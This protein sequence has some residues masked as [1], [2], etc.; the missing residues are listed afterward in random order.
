MRINNNLY[1]NQRGEII[2]GT[3]LLGILGLCAISGIVVFQLEAHYGGK[4]ERVRIEKEKESLPK[5]LK[6]I[7]EHPELNE[8]VKGWIKYGSGWVG[9]TEEQVRI[10][11][12]SW[13]EPEVKTGPDLPLGADKMLI[14][15]EA[16]G[17]NDYYFLKNNKVI[18][19]YPYRRKLKKFTK[20]EE[21]EILQRIYS[22]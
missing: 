5:R 11:E 21:K 4:Y 17:F 12:I 22:N 15:H 19:V 14:F 2:I 6:Y 20:E 16:A 10:A 8:E 7:E 3:I 9:F 1:F 13:D 18:Y